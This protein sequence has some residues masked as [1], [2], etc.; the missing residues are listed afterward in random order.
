MK[1]GILVISLWAGFS[2]AAAAQADKED[3]RIALAVLNKNKKALI[4]DVIK[5]DD[6]HKEV[7]W[8]LYNEYEDK[9]DKLMTG[10]IGIIQQ[11]VAAYDSLGDVKATQLVENIQ[12]N[13]QQ[14]DE[15]HSSYFVKFR[16]VIG[17]RN[18]A[19]LYQLEL[20]IQTAIQFNVQSELPI[21]GQLKQA[22]NQ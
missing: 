18:A 3:V 9:Y 11:Y 16:K 20:Y 19:T 8:K 7:F 4:T 15:L 21:I 1:A 17:G 10:R 2:I 6:T 5:T 13:T 22:Q 14:L 12:K